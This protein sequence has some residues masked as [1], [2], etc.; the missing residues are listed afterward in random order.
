MKLA[1]AAQRVKVHAQR[2]INAVNRFGIAVIGISV[3]GIA[4]IDC[5]KTIVFHVYPV[6][7]VNIFIV[8][9]EKECW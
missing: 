3:I 2:I 9:N 7:V 8:N 1:I 4:V 5:G 6:Q